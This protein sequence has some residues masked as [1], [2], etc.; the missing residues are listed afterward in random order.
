MVK[1]VLSN[2]FIT[3]RE[4]RLRM[5]NV[6]W[7]AVTISLTFGILSQFQFIPQKLSDYTRI[8]LSI[9]IIVMGGMLL[10][11]SGNNR[12][13]QFVFFIFFAWQIGIMWR[14]F[15]LNREVNLER[16]VNYGSGYLAYLAPLIVFFP[17]NLNFYK[18]LFDILFVAGII[19]LCI[20]VLFIKSLLDRSFETQNVIESF[21]ILS[22]PSGFLLLTF[23]YHT[24]KKNLIST[25]VMVVS[26]LFSIYKARRGLSAITLAILISAYFVFLIEGRKKILI[27]YFSVL[28]VLL[29]ALK[30]SDTY[31]L[32]QNKLFSF[33][34]ERGDA[35]TRTGVEIY[36]DEDMS[37][38]DWV[39]GKGWNGQYFC[40]NVDRDQVTNYRNYIE[41]GY[42][43]IILKGGIISLVLYILVLVP[44][45]ILCLFFSKNILSKAAG[46]WI[47]LSILET[48]PA[49]IVEFDFNY[50]L[51]WISAGIGYSGK[52]RD[53]SDEYLTDFF[54]SP[55]NITD[56][57]KIRL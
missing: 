17:I 4:D 16:L 45:A 44:S 6:F 36:F 10:K 31:K 55:Y 19:F 8:L 21:A 15:S 3:I 1:T 13:L 50:L 57:R 40:P 29:G 43:N 53:L 24:R 14:G 37:P 41:T 5:L 9:G 47:I 28:F 2:E 25:G 7:I 35:D 33:L 46:I 42:L 22:I 38:T 54:L 56:K 51:V 30:F 52:I 26:L 20:D 12:F 11:F 49:S 27:L 34:L 23:K 32:G 48:Y 18:K 39:I